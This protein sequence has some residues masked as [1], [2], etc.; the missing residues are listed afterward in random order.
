[1]LLDICTNLLDCYNVHVM[2]DLLVDSLE[3]DVKVE[4]TDNIKWK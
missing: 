4:I 3:T 1:M 2:V